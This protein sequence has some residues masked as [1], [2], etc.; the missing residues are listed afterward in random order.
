MSYRTFAL[1]GAGVAAV[2]VGTLLFGNLN[3]NLVYYLT[4]T[5]ALAQRADFADGRRLRLGGMVVDGSVIRTPIGVRFSVANGAGTDRLVRVVHRGAPA[6][7]FRAGVGVVVEGRW[8]GTTFVSDTMIVKHDAEY[9]PPE[10]AG[11]GGN[12]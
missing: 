7:L 12:R 6:Q 10:S 1:P 11:G 4:P 3:D 5:E 8:Q 2:L 9:R